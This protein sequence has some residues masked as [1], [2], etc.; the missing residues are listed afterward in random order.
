MRPMHE[1][2]DAVWNCEPAKFQ[3]LFL[4]R[5]IIDTIETARVE[6]CVFSFFF[7]LFNF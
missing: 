3:L 2:E 6:F 1:Y 4:H 5:N 7:F